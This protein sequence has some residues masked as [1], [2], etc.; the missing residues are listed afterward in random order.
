VTAAYEVLSDPEKRQMYDL[1][2][3]PY[4]SGGG[5]GA[6]FGF[7]DIMD[8]F[9]GQAGSRGPRPRMRRGQDALIR[10]SVSLDE[11]CFGT[12]RA[13]TVDTA[14]ACGTCAG[15]GTA[16]GTTVSTCEVCRGRGEVQHV[17]RSFLGQ[18]MTSRPCSACQGYGTVIPHPCSECAGDGRVRTRATLEVPIPAGVETGTRIQLAGR[19]EVGPGGGPAGDLYVEIVEESHPSLVREGDHL[20]ASLTIPMTAAALGTLAQVESLDG[21]QEVTIPAGTQSG[22][23]IVLDGLGMGRLRGHGRGD[24][25]VHIDVRTPTRLTAEQEEILR[26]FATLR[27]EEGPEPAREDHSVFGKIRD[28]F[29]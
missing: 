2:Q 29:R 11:A 8:A 4:A 14:V 20:H 1:G 23:R 28:A 5:F 25:V 3:D 27:G 6:G 21:P 22:E 15:A 7:S 12:T 16:P 18:V 10:L 9:F 26:Q 24:L 17:T 19:G 13:I